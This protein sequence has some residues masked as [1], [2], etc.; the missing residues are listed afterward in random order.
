MSHAEDNVIRAIQ[1][2]DSLENRTTE[3]Q[4]AAKPQPKSET[5]DR[6]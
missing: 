4:G 6:H 3:E 5:T 1:A 2:A